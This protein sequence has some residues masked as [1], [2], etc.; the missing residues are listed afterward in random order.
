LVLRAG[1]PLGAGGGEQAQTD[2]GEERE[3]K[4]EREWEVS[5]GERNHQNGADGAGDD[6]RSE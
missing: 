3:D 5:Q 4:D 1:G 2:V 6:I